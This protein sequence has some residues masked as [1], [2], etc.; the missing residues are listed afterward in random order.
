MDSLATFGCFDAH[1]PALTP[2]FRAA[3]FDGAVRPLF[4]LPVEAKRRN[5]CG[6]DKP[7]YGYIGDGPKSERVVRDFA[8]LMW[9]DGSRS[10]GFCK[11]VH[12]AAKSIFELEEAVRRM[13]MEG[14]GVAKYHEQLSASS[15]HLFRIV[16]C[17]NE[18]EGLEARTKAGEWILV[19]PSPTSLVVM[20]GNTLR[21][22]AMTAPVFSRNQI[23]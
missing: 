9:P 3:L 13:V 1:Y 4:S 15:W 7:F 11:A 2:E 5:C 21:V 17:Q 12:G 23:D 10:A 19:Q 6:A 20:A 18:V 16:V 8:D 14:L 22:R